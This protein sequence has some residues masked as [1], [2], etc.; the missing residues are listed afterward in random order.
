MFISSICKSIILHILIMSYLRK[1]FKSL[2]VSQK[3]TRLRKICKLY[4]NVQNENIENEPCTSKSNE[5]NQIHSH[6]ELYNLCS[7]ILNNADIMKSSGS[8]S[9]NSEVS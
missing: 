6:Y 2:S 3:N 5:T 1:N 4:N 9:D 8:D 7:N